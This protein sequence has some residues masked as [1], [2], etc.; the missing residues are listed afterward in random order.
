MTNGTERYIIRPCRSEDIAA[1]VELA[2]GWAAEGSTYGQAPIPAAT[3]RGWL[4]GNFWVAEHDAAVVGFAYASM[5]TEALSVI[6]AGEP[7]LK[8][9][10]LYVLPG[11]RGRGVGGRLVE[12][13]LAEAAAH[14][15][16]HGW[17]YSSAKEWPRIVDFYQRFG[18][19]MWFV[20]LYR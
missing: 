11:H 13:V 10:E 14:G 9:E 17:V 3:A 6:P 15:V 8:L 4:G 12:R 18:F 2:A 20:G 5:Q 16:H 7:Y 19:R 1:V